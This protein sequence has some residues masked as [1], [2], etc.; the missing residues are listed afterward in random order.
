MENPLSEA[1]KAHF[2]LCVHMIVCAHIEAGDGHPSQRT[3]TG[4]NKIR[5]KRTDHPDLEAGKL[6]LKNLKK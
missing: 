4:K 6:A 2:G 1:S 5:N 3:K